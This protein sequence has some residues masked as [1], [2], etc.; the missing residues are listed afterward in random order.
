[1][2]TQL[3]M[4]LVD[5]L[6]GGPDRHTTSRA[7]SMNGGS[8]DSLK[9]S[10]WCGLRPNAFQIRPTVDF[11]RLVSSAIE[12]RDKCVTSIR[13]LTLQ[14]GHDHVLDLLVGDRAG[15]A[16]TRLVHQPHQPLIQEPTPPLAHRLRPD[17]QRRRDIL[18]RRA[19]N[20]IRNLLRR[21]HPPRP[22][23]QRLTFLVGQP[24]CG[25]RRTPTCHPPI[26]RFFN[27]FQARHTRS[28]R[29]LDGRESARLEVAGRAQHLETRQDSVDR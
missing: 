29:Q 21:L 12:A 23:Q 19:P 18:I 16:G 7:L 15:S 13:G 8:V 17:P 24:H 10:T 25:H 22:A 11:D 9:V 4:A 5:G 1:M 26:L 14:G 27:K 6:G 2:R 3:V 28:S 20:T